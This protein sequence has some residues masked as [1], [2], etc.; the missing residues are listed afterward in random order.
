MIADGKIEKGLAPS[1]YLEGLLY[2]VSADKFGANYTTTFVNCYDWL[3][4]ADRSNFVCANEQYY[5]LREGSPVT[6][7]AGKCTQFL[8]AVA[9]YWRN[10]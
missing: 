3:Y 10:W 5:L 8:D 9:D 2:N 7:R 1:Y 4:S 6:W